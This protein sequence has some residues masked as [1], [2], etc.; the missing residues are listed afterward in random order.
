MLSASSS[1]MTLVGNMHIGDL[2]LVTQCVR[3]LK[4]VHGSCIAEPPSQIFFQWA[5]PKNNSTHI[6]YTINQ[7]S[8][9]IA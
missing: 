9:Y 2:Y 3:W 7:C 8:R 4:S 6:V 1:G 5:R